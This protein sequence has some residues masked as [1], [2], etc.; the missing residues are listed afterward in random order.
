[1]C[2]DCIRQEEFR[3]AEIKDAELIALPGQP[4]PDG[5]VLSVIRPAEIYDIPAGIFG[6]R[7]AEIRFSLSGHDLYGKRVTGGD[8]RP[9]RTDSR[10]AECPVF[11]RQM[12]VFLPC[13]RIDGINTAAGICNKIARRI[14]F[15]FRGLA[16]PGTE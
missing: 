16:C 5:Y 6:Q 10:H 2:A 14:A 9:V 3:G 4:Q 12:P 7:Q 11:Q 15:R 1:M 8:I 13:H